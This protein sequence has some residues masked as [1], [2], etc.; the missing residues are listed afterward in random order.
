LAEMTA[1]AADGMLVSNHSYGLNLGSV[2]SPLDYIG[3]YSDVSSHTDAITYNA[4]YYTVVTAAGNDRGKGINNADNGYN[5]LGSQFTTAKNTIVV[6][7][8]EKN[9]NYTGPSSVV[10]SDFSSWGPTKD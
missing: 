8:V 2:N 6:A 3:V 9:L 7:A 4:P 1:A 5:L 10:M